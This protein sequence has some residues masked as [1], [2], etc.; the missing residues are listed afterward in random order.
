MD[1]VLLISGPTACGKSDAAIKIARSLGGE[2]VNIDSVQIYRELDIGSAKVR[3]EE[4]EGVAHHLIDV[5][6][7]DETA[8][9]AWYRAE[10]L[11]HAEDIQ[12]RSKVCV[13]SGGTTMYITLLFHG[14]ASLPAGD[15]ELRAKLL[16]LSPEDLHARLSKVDPVSAAR[17]HPN[18]RI[19]AERAL[20]AYELTGIP[21]SALQSAHDFPAS[22]MKGLFLILCWPRDV[23]YERIDRRAAAMFEEGLLEET[24]AV[25]EKY[26]DRVFPL[27]SLG[28]AQA[29]AVLRGEM[30]LPGAVREVQMETRRFAKRQYTF[31]RNEPRKRGWTVHPGNEEAALELKSGTC[32]YR[33]H[34]RVSDFRVYD[35]RADEVVERV[36]SRL[37]APF[38]RNEVWYLNGARF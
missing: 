29:C 18:D 21:A 26:G 14:I 16:K 34:K 35:W 19:R 38:E 11:N 22:D 7:P 30:D 24:R 32:F 12:N 37:S 2:I 1:P 3:P 20:E 31:W 15:P 13:F 6:S 8:D 28:Y 36:K 27:K 17:I 9:A 23:L 5:R 33:H 25:V 10:A 4:H